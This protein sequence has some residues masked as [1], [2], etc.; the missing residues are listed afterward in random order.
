MDVS[1]PAML[2]HTWIFI[3]T[4]RECKTTCPKAEFY[5][6]SS[7]MNNYVAWS[8]TQNASKMVQL[9]ASYLYTI[10]VGKRYSYVLLSQVTTE[11]TAEDLTTSQ[12]AKYYE[13]PRD[14]VKLRAL[15]RKTAGIRGQRVRAGHCQHKHVFSVH[16]PT[17]RGRFQ[18]WR[19]WKT[20]RHERN[21]FFLGLVML[22]CTCSKTSIFHNVY[23][24][25]C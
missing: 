24:V 6:N 12:G 9:R 19:S 15:E 11:I 4:R 1:R 21:N 25:K 17:A 8:K 14:K 10:I 20:E 7:I 16:N 23:S 22:P 18:C 5:R 3:W 13:K 2:L